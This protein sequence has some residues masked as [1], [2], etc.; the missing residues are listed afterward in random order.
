MLISVCGVIASTSWVVMPL[1]HDPLHPREPTRT[2]FMMSSPTDRTRRLPKWSMSLR[3]VVGVV[4]VQLHQVRDRGE[5]VGLR[6]LVVDRALLGIRV[7]HREV[8]LAQRELGV[9]IAQLLRHLVP[10]NLGH[11]VALGVEEEVLEQLAGGVGR[12]R[13]ARA[14]LAVDVDEGLVGGGGVVLLERVPDRLVRVALR[15][16]DQVRARRRTRRSR[17]P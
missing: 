7:R 15:V 17:A 11:V 8:E 13:L 1:T 10:T 16:E 3:V 14:Q 4:V 5:D 9:L 6:E 2:W 12:G